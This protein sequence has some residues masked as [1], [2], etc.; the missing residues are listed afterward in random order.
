VKNRI[1][2]W[3][4]GLLALALACV[5]FPNSHQANAEKPIP[6]APEYYVLD[7]PGVI[8]KPILESLQALLVEHDH[9]TGE[10]VLVAIFGSLEG[11]DL[12][13]WTNQVFAKWGIGK[14]GK[15]NGVLLALYWKDHKSRIEVGYGLEPVLTDAK[16]KRILSEYLAPELRNGNTDRALTLVTLQILK[17]LD[18]PLLQNG[19][20]QEIMRSGGFQGSW[21]PNR[22]TSK[23]WTVWI[24]LGFILL[25][26]V[27]KILTAADAHFTGRGWYRPRARWPRRPP[28]DD[29]HGNSG[30]WGSFSKGSGAF[31]GGGGLSGGGGASG[32]W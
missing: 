19:R 17:T 3:L 11:E 9:L 2:S 7:E 26:I 6:P 20:A 23:G 16:A 27:L 31:S 1:L 10:Q 24:I 18:S 8:S 28:W 15:D 30:N 14:R 13:S 5:G 29:W 4:F 32:D 25:F 22:T 12:V 21:T